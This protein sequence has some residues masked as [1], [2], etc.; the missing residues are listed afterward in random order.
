MAKFEVKD[1]SE[2]EIQHNETAVI[3]AESTTTSEKISAAVW[4]IIEEPLPDLP[5]AAITAL[6]AYALSVIK[7]KDGSDSCVDLVVK[8]VLTDK[9]YT[10]FRHLFVKPGLVMKKGDE[11]GKKE[12]DDSK[13]KVKKNKVKGGKQTQHGMKTADKIR[14]D[15]AT[16]RIAATITDVIASFNPTNLNPQLGFRSNYVEIVGMTFIYM[17]RFI[18][19]NGAKFKKK[20]NFYQVLALMVSIQRFIDTCSD[21]MGTDPILPSSRTPISQIFIRDIEDCYADLNKMFPFDGETVCQTYPELLVFSPL[22]QY[23]HKTAVRPYAHQKTLVEMCHKY[24][25]N[26][27]PYII[28]YNAMIGSGKTSAVVSLAELAKFFKKKLLCIC[29]LDAVRVQMANLCYNTTTRFAIGSIRMDGSVK[30]TYHWSTEASNCVVIICSP[31]VGYRIRTDKA[32]DDVFGPVENR[33]EQFIVFHDEFTIGADMKHSRPLRENVAILMNLCKW[34]ILSSATSPTIPEL[35]PVIENARIKYPGLIVDKVYSP[36]VQIGCEVRTTDG[37]IVVPYLGCTTGADLKK[38]IEWCHNVPFLGRMLTPNVALQIYNGLL[39]ANVQNVPDIPILFRKVE[40]MKAD[41]IREIVLEMLAILAKESDSLV[42]TICSSRL[43]DND[44]KASGDVKRSKIDPDA[45][46][47]WDTGSTQEDQQDVESR[48]VDSDSSKPVN[49]NK[50]LNYLNLGTGEL[51]RGMTLIA[52]E[53]PAQFMLNCFKSLL[54]ELNANDVTSASRIIN[55]LERDIA[56][57]ESSMTKTLKNMGSQKGG[58]G[59]SDTE[60]G[61]KEKSH[62]NMGDEKGRK[63]QEFYDARPHIKFPEWAQIGTSDHTEKFIPVEKRHLIS[64][65]RIPLILETIINR[66]GVGKQSSSEMRIPDPFILLLFC[67][68]GIYDPSNRLVDPIYTDLVLE[69][70]SKG[71]LAYVFSNIAMA[72]GMNF[73]F[74]AVFIDDGFAKVHSVYT[75]FQL[76]GRAGR[77]GKLAKAQAYVSPDTGRTLVD[78]A[79]H[80][81]RYDIEIRNI[82]D[83]IKIITEETKSDIDAE[84]AKIESEMHASKPI[85]KPLFITRQEVKVVDSMESIG[86]T[87]GSQATG[88]QATGSQVTQVTGSAVHTKTDEFASWE[89]EVVDLK[90]IEETIDSHDT[91]PIPRVQERVQEQKVG[92]E[93]NPLIVPISQVMRSV[94]DRDTRESL[95]PRSLEPRSL[96]PRSL[97]PRSLDPRSLEPR[98]LDPRSLDRK[99]TTRNPGVSKTNTNSDSMSWRRPASQPV[100]VSGSANVN[101]NANA[102]ANAAKRYVPPSMPM[103]MPIQRNGSP[104]QS[105]TGSSFDRTN[106]RVPGSQSIALNTRPPA[107][108]TQNKRAWR[109]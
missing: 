44:G 50:R 24:M 102:N 104:P 61:Q 15:T 17:A 43:I 87:T 86:L 35:D 7:G 62:K 75:L 82:I 23:I 1:T 60:K 85:Q 22:D 78:F 18:L 48:Y 32:L 108:T 36:T 46:F 12:K 72:F 51:W 90:M 93:K 81:E 20:K 27:D 49:T 16:S 97:E 55:T 9:F 64:D 80:P 34:T 4:K 106:P 79:I 29:N 89:E 53:H 5:K 63:E 30:I 73:P 3:N 26:D 40:N 99:T 47:E 103:P 10:M 39:E 59:G 13:E 84:I 109:K 71:M 105:I 68:V 74:A 92:G 100:P 66:K 94:K 19:R 45:G 38:V 6:N 21:Y 96:E 31:D 2:L 28:V 69:F 11:E 41:K 42:K 58:G 33:G 57:W 67:G 56:L 37:D 65:T 8:N 98:S 14:T 107:S 25:K 95:D 52:S 54:D 88:S 101:V 83:M 76:M 70:A 77:V 91:Q